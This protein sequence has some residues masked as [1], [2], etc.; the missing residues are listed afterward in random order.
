MYTLRRIFLSRIVSDLRC[1][2]VQQYLCIYRV[3]ESRN[4]DP[5]KNL[6]RLN[7]KL[8]PTFDLQVRT[9]QFRFGLRSRIDAR[10]L[11]AATLI[12][13]SW[14]VVFVRIFKGDQIGCASF[15]DY[16]TQSLSKISGSKL[17]PP[18]TQVRTICA[19]LRFKNSNSS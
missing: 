3:S 5:S 12:R 4:Y 13:L 14:D 7:R 6:R 8:H 17:R 9:F 19:E 16:E 10:A 18:C 1:L 2:R 11:C 15:T